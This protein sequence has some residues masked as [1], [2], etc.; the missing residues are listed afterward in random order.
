MAS[1]PVDVISVE[2]SLPKESFY[3]NQKLEPGF[4]YIT[5]RDGTTLSASVFLPGPVEDGPYPT[6]VDVRDACVCVCI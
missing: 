1:K 4:N 5:T 3:S 6:V 2:A